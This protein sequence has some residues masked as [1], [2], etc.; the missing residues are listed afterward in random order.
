[1]KE[2]VAHIARE[3]IDKPDGVSV[4][5]IEGNR[6]SVLELKAVKDDLGKI[7]GQQGRIAQA[8]RTIVG[9][10]SAKEKNA[11]SLKSWIKSHDFK[12]IPPMVTW[13]WG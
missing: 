6:T 8:I 13:K 7:I 1:M 2:L 10:V 5:K 4:A 9:S 3:W 12:M 11:P